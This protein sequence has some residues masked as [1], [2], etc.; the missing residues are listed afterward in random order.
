M[1]EL[2]KELAEANKR[3]TRIDE[4]DKRLA[5]T[6]APSAVPAASA[7]HVTSAAP[8]SGAAAPKSAPAVKFEELPSPQPSA[9]S[10]P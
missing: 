4:A 9:S 10:K 7:D 6:P 1:A 5:P 8:T 2:E 3:L